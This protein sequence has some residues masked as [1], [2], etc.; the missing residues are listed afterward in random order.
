MRWGVLVRPGDWLIILLA[1][2][3]CIACARWCWFREVPDRA[4]IRASGQ[5]VAELPLN[6]D[7]VISAMG[8]LGETVIEVRAG[9]A[10][11]Q[12]DPSPRQ[13]CVLQGWLSRAGQIALCLPNQTSVELSG[14]RRRYDSLSY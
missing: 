10:R 13:Y 1:I 6:Q 3:V 4:L 12:R 7:H 14:P 9:Q 5:L 11:V 2:L 8:P